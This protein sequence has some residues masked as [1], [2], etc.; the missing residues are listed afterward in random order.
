MFRRRQADHNRRRTGKTASREE[1]RRGKRRDRRI[2][3]FERRNRN[4]DRRQGY[5][6]FWMRDLGSGGGGQEKQ[7]SSWI[8]G[9]CFCCARNDEMYP[10]GFSF[11]PCSG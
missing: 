10:P 11:P 7:F 5:D 6:E 3:L 4:M 9:L 2:S 8:P 1:E